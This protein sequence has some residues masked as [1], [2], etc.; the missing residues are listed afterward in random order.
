MSATGAPSPEP[1]IDA[2]RAAA[3]RA[4]AAAREAALGEAAFLLE[5]GKRRAALAGAE[6]LKRI[7]ARLDERGGGAP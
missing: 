1:A 2:V 7:A 6:L 5:V 4:F 3:A